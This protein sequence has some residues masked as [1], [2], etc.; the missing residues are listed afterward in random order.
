MSV[1]T[2]GFTLIELLVVIAIIAILAAILFPVFARAREKARGSSCLS[3]L[4][5]I[6]TALMS[7]AQDFDEHFPRTYSWSPGYVYRYWWADLIQPYIRNYQVFV[8]PSGS[9]AYYYYRDTRYNIYPYPLQCSYAMPDMR[10]DLYGRAIYPVPG[11]TLSSIQ[12]SAGT[13]AVVDSLHW[14]IAAGA[15][16]LGPADDYSNFR[17]LDLT[18]LG[19]YPRVAKR[20]NDGFNVCFADGHVKWLNASQPGMWTTILYD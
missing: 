2:R 6:G 3:N 12:D 9:W 18:D 16:P 4:R 14:E 8:C 10:V 11:S 13:I 20:H 7:Y 5:Q 17:L 1:K 19:A 15:P